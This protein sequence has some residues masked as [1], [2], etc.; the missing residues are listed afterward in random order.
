MV[1]DLFIRALNADS[2]QK[3]FCTR[4]IQVGYDILGILYLTEQL[5]FVMCGIIST[6]Y[7]LYVFLQALLRVH[8][9][10]LPHYFSE[11]TSEEIQPR[12]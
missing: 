5:P 10:C 7:I 12:K 1:S 8:V 4:I 11:T 6:M 3:P 9:G 2:L